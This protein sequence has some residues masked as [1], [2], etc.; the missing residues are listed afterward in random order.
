M[1]KQFVVE[2]PQLK[3]DK[4]AILAYQETIKEWQSNYYWSTQGVNTILEYQLYEHFP[5]ENDS[6]ILNELLQKIRELG[7]AVDSKP[8]KFTKILKGGILPDHIDPRRDCILMFPLTDN[9]DK[10]FFKENNVI[11]FEHQYT[12]PTIINGKIMHGVLPTKNDR[13]VLQCKINCD[14]Q[15]LQKNHKKEVDAETK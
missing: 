4:S 10:V 3:Y 14:W 1:G 13:I 5:K 7:L 11:V 12:C 8:F 9:P 15:T 6:E 2:F